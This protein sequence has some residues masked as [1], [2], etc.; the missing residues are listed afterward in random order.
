M[1]ELYNKVKCFIWWEFAMQSD[2]HQQKVKTGG[3]SLLP[4]RQRAAPLW[5][6]SLGCPWP[7]IGPPWRHISQS[8]LQSYIH[9][10]ILSI[11]AKIIALGMLDPLSADLCLHNADCLMLDDGPKGCWWIFDQVIS[12]PGESLTSWCTE[13]S[14]LII[15]ENV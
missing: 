4:G 10:G 3:D 8:L 14:D 5:L 6:A 2:W 11:T 13:Q 1:K 7:V 12:G 9:P 15:S